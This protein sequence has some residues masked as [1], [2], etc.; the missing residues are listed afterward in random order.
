MSKFGIG[1]GSPKKPQAS[2][3]DT[4]A[5]ARILA[6][7][8]DLAALAQKMQR[9]GRAPEV[10][11]G[12]LW[13]KNATFPIPLPEERLDALIAQCIDAYSKDYAP[14][15]TKVPM[16][17]FMDVDYPPPQFIVDQLIPRDEVTLV[18]GDGG[19][20]KSILFLS[21]AAHVACGKDWAGFRV[22]QCPVIFISLEDT[23]NRTM[24]RLQKITLTHKMNPA[25]VAANLQVIDGTSHPELMVEVSEYGTRSLIP[26]QTMQEL[27]AA[28]EGAGLIIID[29][30][31][32]AFGGNEN[33]RRDVIA[34]IQHLIKIA[35]NNRSAV[36]LLAH[37]D[38]AAVRHGGNGSSYSGSSA[39]NNTVRS[40]L[41]LLDVEGQLQLQHE[42][43]N[44]SRRA[45]PVSLVWTDDGVLIPGE[46][47]A[48][49]AR[50]QQRDADF[51]AALE[52][53]RAAARLG[54]LVL[55]TTRGNYSSWNTVEHLSEMESFKNKDGK[56][57]FHNALVALES[58]GLLVRKA[59]LNEQ[60]KLREKWEL[61]AQAELAPART[62][63]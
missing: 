57:R 2:G 32:Q 47:T 48:D 30:T 46:S 61:T 13:D 9:E 14:R 10:I 51:D 39:W 56:N 5:A 6:Q 19:S 53:M 59:F 24:H 34:F 21:V 29:N 63:I 44:H 58:E 50:H 60:R 33:A 37:V 28:V 3:V 41:A 38:K 31:S 45:D 11:H 18:S 26:T 25:K 55:T 22:E 36:V 12:A 17:G 7:E 54:I 42:K 23:G 1:G 43:A 15:L 4:A 52:A 16:S 40:R 35:R 49:A 20:G 62:P 8:E 27:E